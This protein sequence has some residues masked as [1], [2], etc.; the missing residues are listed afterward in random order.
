M[1]FRERRAELVRRMGPGAVAV[2]PASPEKIRNNDVHYPYRQDSD[3]HYLTGFDEPQSVLLLSEAGSVLF[4]RKRDPEREIWDGKRAGVEGAIRD[5]GMD[6]AHTIE[7][8]DTLAP[9]YLENAGAIVYRLGFDASWDA[10]IVSWIETLRR[11]ARLG[12]TPPRAVVDPA[13][14]LHEMRLFKD[15]DEIAALRRAGT[16]TGEAHAAAMREARDGT[17]EYELQATIEGIFRRRGG[18]GPGYGTIVA[19]GVNGTILH[20]RAGNEILREGELCLIDAGAEFESYTADVTRTFPVGGRFT[21]QQQALYE[22]VLAS[23]LAAIDACR[24]GATMDSVHDVAVRVL[25][26]GLVDLGLL[27]GEVNELIEAKAFRRFYMHRTSHWLGMDVHDVGFGYV[28]G[29]PRPLEPGMVLTVEP[30]LYVG[31]G[32]ETVAPEWRGIGIRIEDDVHVAA[33]GPDVLTAGIPKTVAEI[34]A[35]C[36][37]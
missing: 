23:Q 2:L 7:E 16:I 5:F 28:N 21:K 30:G 19:A 3:L 25:T 8:L 4:V 20:Y 12:V 22:L 31:V 27:Q 10:R 34:A 14:Y 1:N 36:G 9:K 17:R 32:D 33:A 6:V 24:P 18:K 37:A 11:R 13:P 26:G 35:A 29:E 15:A